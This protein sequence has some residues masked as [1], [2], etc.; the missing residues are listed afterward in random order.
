MDN[1]ALA[2]R[3]MDACLNHIKALYRLSE[4]VAPQGEDG[5]LLCLRACRRPMLSGELV[6]RLGLTTGR[7]ANI[8][9]QLED[10]GLIERVQDTGDRRRVHVSLTRDGSAQ[11][12][13]LYDA[14]VRAQ[15]TLLGALSE[16]DAREAVRLLE[17]CL[18]GK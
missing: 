9:R 13:R 1:H 10:K 14:H 8:L 11:A 4:T 7:V 16:A 17:R 6:D 15:Q 3:L 5:A 12:D 2:E 18:A